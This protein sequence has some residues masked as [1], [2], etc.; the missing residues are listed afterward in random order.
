MWAAHSV[1]AI[2]WSDG[3]CRGAPGASNGPPGAGTVQG[4]GREVQTGMDGKGRPPPR[5]PALICDGTKAVW[6]RKIIL[7]ICKKLKFKSINAI[8]TSKI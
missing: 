6:T 8:Q 7:G 1:R 4:G 2:G 5:R 3:G